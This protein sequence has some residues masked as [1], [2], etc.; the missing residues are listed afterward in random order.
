VY[1]RGVPGQ[2]VDVSGLPGGDYVLVVS[3][4]AA[5]AIFEADDLRPNEAQ[6]EVTL[7]PPSQPVAL[8]DDH[9]DSPGSATG[10]PSPAGLQASLQVSGD[11]DS[12]RI[13]AQAGQTYAVRTELLGL[14]DSSLR[15]FEADGTTLI[16]ENDDVD[17]GVDASSRLSV[18][19]EPTRDV[20]IEVTGPS[21][22][23]GTHRLI[24]E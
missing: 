23:T 7:P 1:D 13:R 11:I 17:P 18:S 20:T 19:E 16:G 14:P 4:N 10:M 5:G 8:L 2:W 6:V 15:V 24:E 12:F 21:G 9:A 3:V 22:A